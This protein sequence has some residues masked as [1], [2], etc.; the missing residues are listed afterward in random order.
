MWGPILAVLIP[1][2]IGVV[3]YGL[4]KVS[5]ATWS[6]PIGLLGSLLGAPALLAVGAPFGSRSLYPVAVIASVLMWLLIGFLAA[7]RA[8]RNPMASWGDF[9]RHYL[10]M[11]LGVW[12]GVGIA[13]A[14][15][16]VQVGGDVIEW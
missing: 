16:T 6:G 5:D 15:A 12:A 14:V 2:V 1:G 11:L 10:W 4:L 13:L 8:T 9:W 7:R 3:G